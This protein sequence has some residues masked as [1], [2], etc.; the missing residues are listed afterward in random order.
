MTS[1]VRLLLAGQGAARKVEPAVLQFLR[2]TLS[3]P[4]SRAE[5]LWL[6]VIFAVT[7]I[8]I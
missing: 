4:K 2:L 1:P 6:V 3:P 5:R 8:Y 7:L